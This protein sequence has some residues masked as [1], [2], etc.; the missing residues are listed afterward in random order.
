MTPKQKEAL[1]AVKAHGSIRAAARALKSEG[2]G[3]NGA[4]TGRPEARNTDLGNA[5]RLAA[6]H[7]DKLRYC[8]QWGAWLT[9]DGS[10]WAGRGSTL[11]SDMSYIERVEVDI[12]DSG[13]ILAVS[14]PGYGV[15]GFYAGEGR[16]R[17]L[18]WDGSKW[19]RLG[20]PV[21]GDSSCPDRSGCPEGMARGAR[22]SADGSILAVVDSGTG[23][24]RQ[25]GGR[26]RVFSGEG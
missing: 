16:V 5:E 6:R 20:D 1:E 21:F 26:V 4:P 7:G 2:F 8:H 25:R 22:L 10:R 13:G 15:T 23:A 17:V 12:S 14:E 19:V 3:D 24:E 9:W 11:H 18:I